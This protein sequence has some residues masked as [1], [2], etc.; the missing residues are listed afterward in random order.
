MGSKP[1]AS[2]TGNNVSLK[3]QLWTVKQP[4][5]WLLAA[6][7][8]NGRPCS[9]ASGLS[10][11]LLMTEKNIPL[12]GG[13]GSIFTQKNR[14]AEKGFLD[15][16]FHIWLNLMGSE[17]VGGAGCT[18]QSTPDPGSFTQRPA[19]LWVH[20]SSLKIPSSNPVITIFPLFVES[21]E[22]PCCDFIPLLQQ[23]NTEC[24]DY[25]TDFGGWLH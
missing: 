20:Q 5:P 6:F 8:L 13:S 12:P 2:W 3:L 15:G 22:D 16:T 14:A 11:S 10:E 1:V 17:D 4:L 21:S 25:S 23:P 24:V 9:L 7:W 18:L 19:L